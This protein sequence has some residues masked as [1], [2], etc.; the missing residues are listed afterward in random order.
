M[1]F[2]STS[3]SN[4]ASSA[5]NIPMA[6]VSPCHSTTSSIGV[7]ND[8]II[9][10][11]LINHSNDCLI[12]NS[13]DSLL[14]QLSLPS[15][16]HSPVRS[17]TVNSSNFQQ[18]SYAVSGLQSD[19][20]ASSVETLQSPLHSMTD[21]PN[22]LLQLPVGSNTLDANS[23]LL[24]SKVNSQSTESLNLIYSPDPL[25]MAA[26][27]LPPLSPE[28][29]SSQQVVFPVSVSDQ[30]DISQTYQQLSQ[31]EQNRYSEPAKICSTPNVQRVYETIEP[32]KEQNVLQHQV[33]QP[34]PINQRVLN[35]HFL[36]QEPQIL[37]SQQPVRNEFQHNPSNQSQQIVFNASSLTS[38]GK[39]N[40]YKY[41]LAIFPR[42]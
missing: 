38:S 35:P 1:T 7:S 12:H 34:Q 19:M 39:K 8:G 10:E 42:I 24:N 3:H 30:Q 17:M 27:A 41:R 15:N 4:L 25:S 23:P 26:P 14:K 5:Q 36:I 32:G 21:S 2:S 9:R 40:L 31:M 22:S 11:R 28:V 6:V 13:T 16:L 18:S 37:H 20:C 29:A 33:I